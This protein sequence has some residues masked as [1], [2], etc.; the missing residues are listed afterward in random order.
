M[1]A[2]WHV[3]VDIGGTFTDVVAVDVASGQVR[4]L[5]VPS[6]RS[7][8]A[9]GVLDGLSALADES[10]VPTQDIALVFHG[11][12]LATNA[13]IERRL[14]KTAVVT[15]EGFRDVLE[16]GRHWRTELY[17]PFIEVPPPLVERD[18]RLEIE[19]RLAA[20]GSELSPVSD[21]Q[22]AAVMDALEEAEVQ[23][24][25]VVFLH[26]YRNPEH[27]ET[28]AALLRA[29]NGW[30]VCGSAE[31]SRELR[32]YERTSTTVLNAALMP[33]VDVYLDRVKDGLDKA[34]NR[35]SLLIMQSNGGA[36]T[37]DAARAR[38]VTLAVSGP[39]G[40]VVACTEVA[41]AVGRGNVVGLDMGGT[42]TDISII[43]DYESR[44]SSQLTVG[45]MPIRLPSVE[46]HSI[47]A[48][49]GSIASV[50]AGGA[51]RVGP[52][53]AGSEPGPAC[54][55]RGGSQPTVTDC[56]LL[57]GRL[58]PDFAL[59]GRLPLNEDL[60]RA[61]LEPV[62]SALGLSVEDAAAG[63]IDVTNAAMERAVRVALRNRGDDPRDFALMA[64][65]GAG[66][67]H[68][69]ELARR[70]SIQTVVVPP[71][72]G[73]LSAL[74]FLAADIRLDFAAS[75]LRSSDAPDL[76]EAANGIY[77][78]LESQAS[79]EMSN[80]IRELADSITY[81][82]TCDVRYRGQAY[83]VTVPVPEGELD[84][85]A[86]D[87]VLA[88]FHELHER[89]YGFS[90]PDDACE[91][92]TFRVAAK[93]A[94]PQV[95]VHPSFAE[96]NGATTITRPVYIPECGRIATQVYD[97]AR[98]GPGSLISGPAIVHQVDATTLI[99]GY[100]H[101]EVDQH[102]NII[103]TIAESST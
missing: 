71:H 6:S 64:F 93:A 87:G 42:S 99:P 98:L 96:S 36:L 52:E 35:G 65:G 7:D 43:A 101:G 84:R 95:P 27:E 12:T 61:A 20:D 47:G 85:P 1:S 4:H 13:I 60:A 83:E 63:V 69:I 76:L 94:L 62:A 44:H 54:Y 89:A 30:Y 10:G 91:L 55:G 22:A 51:V 16:I 74:G 75:D 100:A 21:E 19:E 73:T 92:V 31:L 103:V 11:T 49:G 68:A 26:S 41:R 32:E 15:T 90:S 29:R 18:L 9:R 97:R 45:E 53:S 57:L 48:G 81:D 2:V 102:G 72:P 50:D 37:P 80:E 58:A 79:A 40:G 38:P 66:A 3:G 78:A 46:V 86:F 14:A 24:V 56:Q 5:K 23:A 8:P 33:L 77:N 70:L 59:A 88:R 39:V 28:M 17:D 82:R 25:A 67:L 34:G